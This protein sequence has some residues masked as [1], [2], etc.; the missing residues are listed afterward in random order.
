M[1]F[2][3]I[4]PQK[5]GSNRK[6]SRIIRIRIYAPETA[7]Y[8]S[9]QFYRLPFEIE[10]RIIQK[11]QHQAGGGA[12]ELIDAENPRKDAEFPL[13]LLIRTRRILQKQNEIL[14]RHPHH[15]LN[16]LQK[17][18]PQIQKQ[19]KQI[20]GQKGDKNPYV[21]HFDKTLKMDQI[22]RASCRERV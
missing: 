7:P 13:G 20:A 5:S 1:A 4:D 16:R 21:F 9:R 19:R 18:I 10:F 8:D 2:Y 6:H 15:R 14:K 11:Q 22:G 3:Q 17:A 12:A